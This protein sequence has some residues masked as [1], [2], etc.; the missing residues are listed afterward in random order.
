MYL[1]ILPRIRTKEE[2]KALIDEIEILLSSLYESAG[3]GFESSFKSQIRNWVAKAMES[4][5]QD[6]GVD[7]KDYL[8]KLKDKLNSLEVVDLV[9]AYEPN[10]LSLDKFKI[11][12]IQNISEDIIFNITFDPNLLGG[13]QIVYKGEFRDFSLKRVFEQEIKSKKTEIIELIK[14]K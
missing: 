12:M 1:E 3:E 7:K 11:Y 5:W 10:N 2:A 14:S 6:L 8:L 9:L 13:V 4:D